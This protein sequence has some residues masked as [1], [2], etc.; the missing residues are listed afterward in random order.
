MRRLPGCYA[1]AMFGFPYLHLTD[2]DGQPFCDTTSDHKPV[3]VAARA[4]FANIL[5]NGAFTVGEFSAYLATGRKAIQLALP[6]CGDDGRMNGVIIAILSL[7]WLA[8]YIARKGTPPGAA[9]AITDRNGTYLAR[10]PANDRFVGTKM[11]GEKYLNMDDR[12]AVDILD[13]DGTERIEAYSALQADSG[14]LVVSFGLNKTGLPRSR[15]ARYA[16]S[17]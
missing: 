17:S 1:A 3:N 14:A 15:I 9:L 5:K 7:D 6:F 8:D 16:T 11:P 2:L 10:H 4:Y 13:V 12:G